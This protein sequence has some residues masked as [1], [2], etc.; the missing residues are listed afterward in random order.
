MLSSIRMKHLSRFPAACISC[1]CEKWLNVCLYGIW[2][3]ISAS[4][5]LL[6]VFMW[7]AYI[8]RIS[9][10]TFRLW[11]KRQRISTR[12][13]WAVLYRFGCIDIFGKKN[14]RFNKEMYDTIMNVSR[15]NSIITTLLPRQSGP[16]FHDDIFKCVFLNENVWISIE[17]SPNFVA[18][19]PI[20]NITVLFQIMA[21][22]LTGAKALFESLM[23]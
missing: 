4:S 11:L 1:W 22:R 13:C 3:I 12:L 2:G 14:K 9:Q 17:N 6:Q 19:G 15:H 5:A 8:S 7:T 23:A 20:N 21:W 16:Y 18:E 10:S